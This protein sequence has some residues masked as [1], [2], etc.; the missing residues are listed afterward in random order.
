MSFWNT[1]GRFLE[2]RFPICYKICTPYSSWWKIAVWSISSASK[3]SDAESLRQ[4]NSNSGRVMGIVGGV[5]ADGCE[6]AS[7]AEQP[8]LCCINWACNVAWYQRES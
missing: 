5:G 7:S 8:I 1:V 4:T 6:Q 3:I 2:I